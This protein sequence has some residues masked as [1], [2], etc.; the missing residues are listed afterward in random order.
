MPHG[1][2]IIAVF[3]A[4]SLS[5]AA[6]PA[7]FVWKYGRQFIG[8]LSVPAGFA[9]ETY[10]YREGIVP[11]GAFI[12]LQAG[13]LYR[14]PLFQEADH[15]LLSSKELDAKTIRNGRFAN[16]EIYWREDNYKPRRISGTPVSI[17]TLFPPNLGYAKVP[18]ARRAQFDL[19]LDSF[20]REIER[21]PGRVP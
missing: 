17:V 10:N 13:G 16:A 11:D 4:L 18:P 8:R 1:T 19:A 20:T 3:V 7:E 2:R 9:V 14:I 6:P 21:I 5:Q 15:I 12:I